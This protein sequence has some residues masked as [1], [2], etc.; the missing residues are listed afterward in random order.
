MTQ[1]GT[2]CLYWT[3]ELMDL[4]VFT[5]GGQDVYLRV[6]ASDLVSRSKVQYNKD[7]ID[8]PQFDFATIA[9]ATE[10]FSEAN[11]LGK[12]KVKS[13]FLDWAK[14]F[15]IIGGIAKGILYLHE[16]SRLKIIHRDLK[17]SNILLD[18][19]MNPKVSDFGMARIFGGDETEANTMIIVGTR[20]YIAP[21]YAMNG[22][23][24]V[25]SDVFS[26]GVMVL[27]IIN[28]EQNKG[29]YYVDSES[30]LLA[31]VSYSKDEVLRCIQVAHL[32]VQECAE[33]RPT[34]SSVVLM[35]NSE[36]TK[37]LQP[38]FPSFSHERISLEIS[39][40]PSRQESSTITI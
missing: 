19:E 10:N 20:G 6:S 23:F 14:R 1:G 40:S 24:S 29:F 12:D 35:L 38:K 8:L 21:E 39:E 22:I 5:D 28:G 2:G 37:L 18:G 16:D 4:R 11:E 15:Q 27:E 26:F 30:I 36:T 34:M 25:K 13:S 17:A 33:E 9:I 32:C 31:H 7:D 3:G